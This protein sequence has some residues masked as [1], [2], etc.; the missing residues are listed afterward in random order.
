MP[1]VPRDLNDLGRKITL[2]IAL[3]RRTRM[4]RSSF[5]DIRWGP[6]VHSP[7]RCPGGRKGS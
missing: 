3:L 4:V 7:W 1:E 2:K 6:A 5:D